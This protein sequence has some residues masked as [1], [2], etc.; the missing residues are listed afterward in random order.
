MTKHVVV[1]GV[2]GCGKSTVAKGLAE[3]FGWDLGEADEFHP[4]SNIAK[5]ESGV[6]LNDDDRR[7]WLEDLAAWMAERA[8]EGRSTVIACSALKRSYRD[9]LRD[10]PPSL[11]FI[12]LYGPMEVI[13][14]RLARRKGHFM[15]PSLLQSQFQTLEALED[16]ERGITLDLRRTPEELIAAAQHWVEANL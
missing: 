13:A 10:G 12:H 8:A 16:G 15:S 6:P 5:M 3:I 7:P 14:E 1:M 2:S 11:G 4:P 9:I